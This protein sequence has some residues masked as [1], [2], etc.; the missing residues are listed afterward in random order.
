MAFI[1]SLF[2]GAPDPEK[3]NVI[4]AASQ[5]QANQ[6]FANTQQGLDQQQAFINALQGQN[7]IGNQSSVFN[8]LQGVASGQGPN[9]AQAMLANATGQNVAQQAA[10]MASQRGA[11]G[12]AGLVARNA[13]NVG[14]GIQQNAAGQG[15]AMQAQQSL[16]ALGQLGGIAGQQVAQQQGALGQYNQFAQ[17]QQQNVNSA[18]ANQNQANVANTGQYNQGQMNAYNANTN[19]AGG[20][21][22]G[23]GSAIIGAAHGGEIPAP[24][25][26]SMS[27][28]KAFLLGTGKPVMASQ[29][30]IVP[31]QAK[32][33]GDN[34][35]NDTV[36]AMLSPGEIVIPRSIAQGRNAPEA[37]AKFVA[38]VLS[39][40]GG[41]LPK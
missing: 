5:Q 4:N 7:G 40:K 28:V 21:I 30:A 19:L 34:E 10:L 2:S 26:E 16:N 18:I 6:A 37:A 33:A 38:A 41:R 1:G 32:V 27:H 20:I 12:N 23:I 24:Q 8:Q 14:A 22:G 29:G 36:P 17:G 3:A 25:T 31:G 15:A 39:R 13:A 35:K 9:P 11:S